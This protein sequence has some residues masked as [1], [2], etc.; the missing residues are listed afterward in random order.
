M[1]A[2]RSIWINARLDGANLDGA[3]FTGAD[4]RASHLSRSRGQA[5]FDGTNLGGAT[6]R[7]AEGAPPNIVNPRI[8]QDLLWFRH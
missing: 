2:T 3:D 7:W 8:E 1:K 4:L 6:G 5:T